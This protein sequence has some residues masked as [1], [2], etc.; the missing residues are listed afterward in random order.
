MT[1][2]TSLL[3]QAHSLSVV[4]DGVVMLPDIDLTL[5]AGEALIV[6]GHNGAGKSTLLKV[7]AGL[8]MPTSGTVLIGGQEVS[9]RKAAFRAGVASMIGLPPM[10]SDLTIRDHIRL[11]AATWYRDPAVAKSKADDVLASLEV[12]HLGQR[13][14]HELSTGQVQLAG[15]SLV[16]VRPF[17][18]LLLDEPEQRLDADRLGLIGDVLASRRDQGAS[19]VVATHSPVL[20]ARLADHVLNLDT[21]R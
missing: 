6:R 5:R 20:T 8:R 7:L 16:L 9:R 19:L 11:V 21:A 14:P 2:A 13:F 18:L 12:D 17:D 4:S 15:L 3:I 10:A 1:E